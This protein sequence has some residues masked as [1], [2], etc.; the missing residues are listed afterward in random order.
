MLL[1]HIILFQY[2]V[3]SLSIDVLAQ[4]EG[5]SSSPVRAKVNVNVRDVNDVAPIVEMTSSNGRY[6][7]NQSLWQVAVAEHSRNGTE[8]GHLSVSDPDSGRGGHVTCSMRQ[9]PMPR[10]QVS[11]FIYWA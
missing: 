4:D 10:R 11:C 2:F 5:P 9:Q 6:D 8:V 1:N 3:R 7:G